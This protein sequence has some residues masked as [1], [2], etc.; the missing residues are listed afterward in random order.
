MCNVKFCYTININDLHNFEMDRGWLNDH[1]SMVHNMTLGNALRQAQFRRCRN[2]T[3]HDARI[4]PILYSCV[5]NIIIQHP[6]VPSRKL[7]SGKHTLRSEPVQNM[8]YIPY[9]TILCGHQ[10]MFLHFLTIHLLM[11]KM[12]GCN[13]TQKRPSVI[14][15]V[16]QPLF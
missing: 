4:E 1:L 11:D 16:N 6:C 5:A 2:A 7:S 12:T 13:A 10:G 14:T 3:Q 15:I 9:L 8:T